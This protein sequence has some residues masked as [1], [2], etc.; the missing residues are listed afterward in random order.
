M[1]VD[2]RGAEGNRQVGLQD[3]SEV[4]EESK[5]EEEAEVPPPKRVYSKA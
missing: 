2:P 3:K 1:P 5:E 4:K